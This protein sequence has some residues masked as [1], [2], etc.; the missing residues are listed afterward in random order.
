MIAQHQSKTNEHYTPPDVVE[1]ARAV[2]G[3]IDLDPASCAEAN[4][5]V[6]AAHFYDQSADGLA[7]PWAGR[8]FLNP[9]GGVL[10][11]V[12]GRWVVPAKRNPHLDQ[13]SAAVWWDALVRAY[14]ARVV[15]SAVFIGFTLEVLRLSQAAPYPIQMFPR[16]YPRERMRFGGNAPTHANVIVY[17]PPDTASF[18]RFEAAFGAFG[19]CERGAK[20]PR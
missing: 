11:W 5:V 8:V 7:R 18:P 3:S 2:L 12:D 4:A 16:C 6:K 9:P 1:A 10:R 19:F 20:E 15:E 17:L 13:S 14:A